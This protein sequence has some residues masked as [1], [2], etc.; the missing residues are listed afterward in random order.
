MNDEDYVEQ[1]LP[2]R[3]DRGASFQTCGAGQR[4]A[5]SYP[6]FALMPRA[7]ATLEGLITGES[8][9]TGGG[10]EAGMS[11]ALVPRATA[12]LESCATGGALV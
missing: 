6:L 7:T 9:L 10:A 2:A 11:I 8:L 4:R 1:E 3:P 12:T 5:E